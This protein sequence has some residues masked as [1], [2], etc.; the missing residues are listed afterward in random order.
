MEVILLERI[1]GLGGLGDRVDVK[2][3][4]ARN[5][6]VPRHKALFATERNVA[7]FEERRAELE[8][9]ASDEL[10]RAERRREDIQG[11]DLVIHRR[12]GGEGRLFGSVGVIDVAEAA[13]E[14]GVEVRRNE[15]RMPDGPIRRVGRY[16]VLARVHPDVEATVR[17]SVVPLGGSL[18]DLAP[19]DEAVV[20]GEAGEGEAAAAGEAT[21]EADGTAAEPAAE[22]EAA[23]EPAAEAAGEP[24]AEAAGEPE[25]AGESGPDPDAAGESGAE[26][27][28]PGAE[29]SEAAAAPADED[30]RAA[31]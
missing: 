17:V 9:Q 24:V 20:T 29:P 26:A 30:E 6:L 2:P 1:A 19:E 16:E 25:A 27:A 8:R 11:L 31:G 3:G 13:T 4:Y 10:V 5:Y 14:A 7:V 15:V 21:A 23:S 18:E 22:P 12:A 28:G